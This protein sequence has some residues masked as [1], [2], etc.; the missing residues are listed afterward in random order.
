MKAMLLRRPGEPL[1]PVEVPTPEV[2]P[3]HVLVK[4]DTCAVCRTDLHVI[5]GELSGPK[6]PLILGHEI[7]GTITVRGE[8]VSNFELG[9]R[10]GIPWLGWTCGE[11]EYCHSSRENLC[12]RAKFTG[13]TLDGG[14]AEYLVADP[15]FCFRIPAIYSDAEAAPL[16]CAG[17]IGHRS[18]VKAGDARRLGI[19]GFGAAAHIVAQ[20]ARFQGRE[21]YAFTRPLDVEAQRFAR[22]LGAAWV[23]DSDVRPP[24]T[25]DAA[26]L[27]APVGTLVPLALQAVKP[28]GTVVCGGI[29]IRPVENWSLPFRQKAGEN[30][31]CALMSQHSETCAECLRM[32]ARLSDNPSSRPVTRSCAFGLFEIA[33]P[34]VVGQTKVALLVTGQAMHR[35]PTEKLFQRALKSASRCRSREEEV[36]MRQAFFST[37]VVP[38]NK[39]NAIMVLLAEFADHLSLRANQLSLLKKRTEL[40]AMSRARRYILE[41]LGEH[42]SLGTVAKQVNVSKF[43]FCKLFKKATDLTFTDF[44]NRARI[45]RAKSLLLNPHLRISEVAFQAGFQSLTHFNRAFKKVQCQSPTLYRA[46]CARLEKTDTTRSILRSFACQTVN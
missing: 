28:G 14:F 31:W 33:V 22:A 18:L 4:V 39:S 40:P 32:Q 29:H 19:Y 45:E 37:P 2:S 10:V 21:V 5:D 12:Q 23:G 3:G 44:V 15:R 43:Y 7:V 24:E 16:L 41:H 26:I 13:Y 30:Q 27:F 11:C 34:V 35:N 8:G 6:L 38:L 9:D 42:L 36:V 20:V 17:L 25:L 1:R 46:S